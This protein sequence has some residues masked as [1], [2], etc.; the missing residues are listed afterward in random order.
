MVID[1]NNNLDKDFI[2]CLND[3]KNKYGEDLTKLNGVSN[4]NLNFTY[5]I[6]NVKVN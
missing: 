4:D 5:F 2:A 3:L 6:Y 1:F